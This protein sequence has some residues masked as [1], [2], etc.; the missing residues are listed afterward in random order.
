[1][2][3]TFSTPPNPDPLTDAHIDTLGLHLDPGREQVLLLMTRDLANLGQH[4]EAIN[5]CR[6]LTDEFPFSA[7]PYELLAS[8]AQELGSDEEAK[9]HLKKALYLSPK[10]PR[11][12]MELGA[13]Y[14]KEG[15]QVRAKKMRQSALELLRD[16][17][18]EET[19]GSS[20]RPDTQECIRIL[21][22]L[23]LE[24]A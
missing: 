14:H 6:K 1:V 22:E 11:I 10:S 23:S 8:I 18:S 12:Y 3:R 20:V 4:E 15:D 5:C 17:P 16:S 9:T 13:L 21:T 7:A 2:C 24:G 19:I